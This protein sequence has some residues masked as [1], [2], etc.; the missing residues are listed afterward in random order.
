MI[1]GKV[2]GR[3]VATRKHDQL[4]GNK[5]LICEPLKGQ[6]QVGGKLVAIDTVGAGI[7]EMVLI[8]TGSAARVAAASNQV[9]VDMAIIG[10]IDEENDLSDY[11]GH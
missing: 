5:F 7:G 1:V 11:T 3:L 6:D 4:V 10:I 9:P 8:T 2:I